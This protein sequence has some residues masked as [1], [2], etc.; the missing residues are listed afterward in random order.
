MS[1]LERMKPSSWLAHRSRRVSGSGWLAFGLCCL[2]SLPYLLSLQNFFSNDD[3]VHIH[4]SSGIAPRQVWR[5]FSPQVI[6]FYRPFQALQFGWLYHLAGV[7]PFFYNLS[8]LVLH[9]AVCALVY[10]L[11]RRLTSPRTAL[12]ASLLFAAQWLCSNVMHWCSNFNTIHWALASLSMSLLFVRYLDTGRPCLL[13]ATYGV[14]LVNFLT[15]E[16]AVNAPLLMAALW[17]WHSGRQPQAQLPASLAREAARLLGPAVLMTALYI[18]L[19]RA[20]VTDIHHSYFQIDYRFVAPVQAVRQ[21]LL[22][23]NLVLL[24]FT[25]DPLLLPML[26]WLR[27]IL[28][29]M[30]AHAYLAPFLLVLLAWKWRDRVLSLG[31]AW[32]FITLLPTA[33]LEVYQMHRFFY[34]P[35]FGAALILARLGQRLWQWANRSVAITCEDSGVTLQGYCRPARVLARGSRVLLVLSLAYLLVANCSGVTMACLRDQ[36]DSRR[37]QSAFI[38]LQA[39]RHRF[40]RG[41]LLI[42]RGLPRP[43]FMRGMGVPEMVRLALQDPSAQAIL[44]EQ[45]LTPYW[46]RSLD[47]IPNAYLIDIKQRPMALQCLREGKRT[48]SSSLPAPLNVRRTGT[49]LR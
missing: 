27:S 36:A 48:A 13:V 4:R 11:A 30:A 25:Q 44:Q 17:C 35:A 26:P 46:T 49:V 3:W 31:I 41:S 47:A 22:S 16:S 6:W 38:A 14:L 29:S 33:W 10:S 12:V 23:F 1:S 19:H 28:I 8:A 21:T 34:L 7:R 43:F 24:S 37:V 40:P 5:Y 32:V 42:L 39:E 15:K 18:G 2:I 20:F 45:R 9:L